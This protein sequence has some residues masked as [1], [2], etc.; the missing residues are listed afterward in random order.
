MKLQL[1]CAGSIA[2]TAL[3]SS[4]A[5]AGGPPQCQGLTGQARTSCLN[6]DIERGKRELG[7]I[8][9]A[10]GR[11]DKAKTAVCVVTRSSAPGAIGGAI[12]DAALRQKKPCTKRAY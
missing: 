6:A 2:L 11:L 12:G 9:R 4:P 5:Y 10:N 3:A 7:A 1:I 8:E